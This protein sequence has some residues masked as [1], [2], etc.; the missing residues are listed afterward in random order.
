MRHEKAIF[1]FYQVDFNMKDDFNKCQGG[2]IYGKH[3]DIFRLFW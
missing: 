3:I 1:T 2:Q